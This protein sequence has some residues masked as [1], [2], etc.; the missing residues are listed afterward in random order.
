MELVLAGLKTA[1]LLEVMSTLTIFFATCRVGFSWKR[2]VAG[3][4]PK[5]LVHT[6]RAK[7]KAQGPTTG[8]AGAPIC[9]KILGTKRTDV[10]WGSTSVPWTLP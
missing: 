9:R 3:I 1:I 5:R 2:M 6:G 8:G 7:I 4:L 10:P